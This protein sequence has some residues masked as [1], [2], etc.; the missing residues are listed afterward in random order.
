VAR[1]LAAGLEAAGFGV[2]LGV[3]QSTFRCDLAVRRP[4]ESRYALGVLID[5]DDYF[6]EADALERDMMKPRLLRNFGWRVTH[7]LTKDWH[8]DPARELQRVRAML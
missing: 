5:G 8:A 2:D 1:A 3:G 6:R 7:V 4:G